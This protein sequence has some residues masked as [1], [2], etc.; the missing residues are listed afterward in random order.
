MV[1]KEPEMVENKGKLPCLLIRV[2]RVR[3]PEGAH[4]RNKRKTLILKAFRYF[5]AFVIPCDS[6]QFLVILVVHFWYSGTVLVQKK[7]DI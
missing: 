6:L 4:H 3:A 1:Q 7:R 2:S 5:S